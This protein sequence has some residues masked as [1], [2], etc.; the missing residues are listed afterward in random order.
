MN[1]CIARDSNGELFFFEDKPVWC[2]PCW[3]CVIRDTET[4]KHGVL[5]RLPEGLD[6]GIENIPAGGGPVQ[7]TLTIN[8]KTK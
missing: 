2:P 6:V 8:L 5:L 4:Q 7:A 3:Y 1:G